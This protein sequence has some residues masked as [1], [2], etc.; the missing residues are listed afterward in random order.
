[1]H[2]TMREQQ[3]LRLAR[4]CPPN[5]QA[6]RRVLSA[7]FDRSAWR[8]RLVLLVLAYAGVGALVG[9]LVLADWV[10]RVAS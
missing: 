1:M 10:T 6:I 9:V 7:P 8:H 4:L 2:H 5:R 3:T